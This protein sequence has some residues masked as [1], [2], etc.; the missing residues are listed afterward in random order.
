MTSVSLSRLWAA[1]P[2]VMLALLAGCATTTHKGDYIVSVPP[3]DYRVNHPIAIGEQVHTMV[4]PVGPHTAHLTPPVRSNIAGFAERFR[5]SGS[6]SLLV[7]IPTDSRAGISH[8]VRDTL[9]GAGV[10][11]AK[12]DI[13]SYYPKAP[14]A[15]VR[16]AYSGMTA[17]VAGCGKWPDQ[18]EKDIHNRNYENFGC[19]TQAN[20]AA[21]VANPLDL[22]YPR[23]TTPPDAERRSTVLERYRRGEA[24]T[25]GQT[26]DRSSVAGIGG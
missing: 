22:K 13:R 9:I 8:Q 2:A 6:S 11:P 26:L 24:Y 20:L 4:I 12:V 17:S 25:S 21:M 18:L 15:P 3:D 23:G 5:S 14:G 16:L 1:G 7:L 10:T 19:A